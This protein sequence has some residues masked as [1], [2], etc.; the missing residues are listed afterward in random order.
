[1]AVP[2]AVCASSGRT[3]NTLPAHTASLLLSLRLPPEAV[4]LA[5]ARPKM[6]ERARI[7]W[8]KELSRSDA[9]TAHTPALFALQGT[10]SLL[11]L[12]R[13]ILPA[14]LFAGKKHRRDIPISKL[15]RPVSKRVFAVD[16]CRLQ[17]CLVQTRLPETSALCSTASFSS[18]SR[19]RKHS[20]LS[21]V[22]SVPRRRLVRFLVVCCRAEKCRRSD[23]P[24]SSQSV[25]IAV[26]STSLSKC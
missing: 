26:L 2:P 11:V 16:C 10:N 19:L 9:R 20:L 4:R 18:D 24:R 13:S 5:E 15:S 14:A 12:Q 23:E 22:F 17:A 6:P 21:S 1:M 3:A 7:C 25:A 8:A